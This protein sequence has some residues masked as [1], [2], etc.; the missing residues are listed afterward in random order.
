VSISDNYVV[1]DRSEAENDWRDISVVYSKAHG[2]HFL[3]FRY[4]RDSSGELPDIREEGC[5]HF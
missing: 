4:A 5:I 1:A 2:E 3:G